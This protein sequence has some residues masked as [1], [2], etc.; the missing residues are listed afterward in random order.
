MTT[1]SPPMEARR[2]IDTAMKLQIEASI[3]IVIAMT[4]MSDRVLIAGNT[5]TTVLVDTR[6]ATMGATVV[7]AMVATTTSCGPSWSLEVLAFFVG[8]V[9]FRYTGWIGFRSI[10]CGILFR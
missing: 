5:M 3:V 10:C 7:E 6:E 2:E 9:S 4:N 8:R 1:M